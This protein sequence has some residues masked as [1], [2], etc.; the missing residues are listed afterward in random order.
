MAVAPLAIPMLAVTNTSPSMSA[1]GRAIACAIASTLAMP[2]AVSI[3]ISMPI[4]LVRFLYCSICVIIMSIA[5]SSRLWISLTGPLTPTQ[6]LM[7]VVVG[8]PPSC[9]RTTIA[10][11]PGV[12][13]YFDLSFQHASPTVL[14]RMRRFGGTESFLELLSSARALLPEAGARSNVIVGFPGETRADVAELERF[15]TEARLDA[16]GVFGYS[17]EDGT[18][19]ASY[20]GKLDEDVVAGVDEHLA[21]EVERL[22]RAAGD[23][24]LVRGGRQPAA[25]EGA[26]D[27]VADEPQAV[28]RPPNHEAE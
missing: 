14:R 18:E 20:D 9:R 24:H 12:V 22:L 4:L 3:R 26:P 19:A 17:D 13:P 10:R 5:G 16:I 15:L 7:S 21:D 23:E 28:L 8:M 27:P 2:S 11:T 1:T 6:P 25:P